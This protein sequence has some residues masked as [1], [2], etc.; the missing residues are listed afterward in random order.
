MTH[1]H[2]LRWFLLL[3]MLATL[4]LGLRACTG[5]ANG[6]PVATSTD[7]VPAAPAGTGNLP[8]TDEAGQL[9]RMQYA[10]AMRSAVSTL[11]AYIA[12]LPEP[13]RA[14]AD[15]FW[16][17]ERPAPDARE[18]DLRDLPGPPRALRIRNGAPKPLDD[19]PVPTTVEIPVQLRLHPDQHP[20][21]RYEGWYRLRRSS[22]GDDWRI[23]GAAIDALPPPG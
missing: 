11:H 16:V 6:P 1:R 17:D 12:A 13:D 19:P 8:P 4:W 18:A 14:K 9:L 15:A 10:A 23:T 20:A 3:L 22:D 21:R 7:P 5:D 2:G